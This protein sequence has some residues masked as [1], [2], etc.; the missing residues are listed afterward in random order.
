VSGARPAFAV[1]ACILTSH[2]GAP[3]AIAAFE[4]PA[5]SPESAAGGGLVALS[6]DPVFG[7]PA[8]AR[9]GLELRA[10][11]DR[12][13]GMTELAE[14]QAGAARA[15]RRAA[16]GLGLRRFGSDA[17]TEG[18]A[19]VTGAWEIDGVLTVGAALR[20]MTVHGPAFAARRSAA[21][22]VAF[23]APLDAGTVV[24]G[25]VEAVAGE[26]PGDPAGRLRRTSLGVARAMPARLGLRL[27]LQRREDRPVAA[28]VGLVWTPAS[29][30]EIRA[31]FREDPATVSWGFTIGLGGVA[32][33]AAS[34]HADPLGRTVRMGVVVRR[35]PKDPRGSSR[36]GPRNPIQGSRE[37]RHAGP[38]ARRRGDRRKSPDHQGHALQAGA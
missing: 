4:R 22:D 35:L 31:G 21:L 27:E 2:I 10:S 29:A 33:A 12:P 8:A 5:L 36:G 37:D 23:A 6:E 14:A 28:A 9:P 30:V 20:G 1:A 16:A 26:I 38:V 7:N 18:E 17:Y 15:G 3:S 24:A 19:R 25:V 11:G 34:T 32:V 13:F